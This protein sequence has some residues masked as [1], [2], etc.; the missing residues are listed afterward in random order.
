MFGLENDINLFYQKY[1]VNTKR[2]QTT[3][4]SRSKSSGTTPIT[5]QNSEFNE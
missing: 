2:S 5:V 1:E 4:S 3:N